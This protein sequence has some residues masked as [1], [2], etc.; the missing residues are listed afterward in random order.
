MWL[1]LHAFH[2]ITGTRINTNL[3]AFVYKH[4]YHDL[5]TGF[6]F[7]RFGCVGCGVAADGGIALDDLQFYK[8]RR[9]II[10][11]IQEIKL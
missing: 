10:V 1:L 6:N 7:G 2:V 4:R 3:V 9:N 11:K 8:V 5:V